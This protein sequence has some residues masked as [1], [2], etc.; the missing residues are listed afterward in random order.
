LWLDIIDR[1]QKDKSFYFVGSTD[2]VIEL[3]VDKLKK[4]YPHI[5]IKGY[6]NG[7]FTNDEQCEFME[8]I[9]IKSLTLSL[10]Q[11]VHLSRN[12]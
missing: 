8:D 9:K 7:Y 10:W 11:W 6:R 3:T 5:N 1:F 4:E 12:I 2:S